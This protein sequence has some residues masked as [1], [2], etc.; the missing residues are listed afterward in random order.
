MRKKLFINTGTVF[1]LLVIT[2][3][4]STAQSVREKPEAFRK[5]V[6]NGYIPSW[7]PDGQFIVYG[8][9]SPLFNV[10]KVRLSDLRVERL[11]Q[12]GGYHPAVSPDG[13]FITYDS[14]GAMG[15]LQRIRFS[16]GS[17]VP[18]AKDTIAGNF[19]C[20]SPDRKFIA[21][22]NKG[23]L[24]QLNMETGE[25]RSLYASEKIDTRPSWSPDGSKIAF[26]SGDPR[27][28]ANADIYTL[29]VDS[30]NLKQLTDHPKLDAQPDWSPDGK[31]IAFLSEK[32]GNRDIWIMKMDGSQK[33]QLTFDK[34]MDVWPRWSPD[35]KR[36]AYGS[37]RQ[38]KDKRVF[39]IWVIDLVRQLGDDFFQK[40]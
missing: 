12:N 1:F 25:I 33:T 21:Y 28:T 14:R 17:Q 24:W 11:T 19:S 13:Q 37:Q 4:T 10:F 35:G 31:W 27:Q 20:W 16:D 6:S 7:S 15:T 8:S 29:E 32:S 34:G 18:F 30:K 40:D 38:V 3:L 26:D 23:D 36:I 5:I 9:T 22:T 39:D 2:I